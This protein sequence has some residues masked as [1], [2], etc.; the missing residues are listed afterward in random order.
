MGIKKYQR[1]TYRHPVF[2]EANNAIKKWIFKR[3][4]DRNLSTYENKVQ[5]IVN[6]YHALCLEWEDK[7]IPNYKEEIFKSCN[8]RWLKY[9]RLHSFRFPKPKETH[10]Q[11][12]LK[13]AS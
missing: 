11:D 3:S 6:I 2:K 5:A 8:E 7:G 9:C 12:Y 1:L 13:L 4:V 10:F